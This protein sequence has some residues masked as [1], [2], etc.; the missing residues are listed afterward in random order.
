ML[1]QLLL[2]AAFFFELWFLDWIQMCSLSWSCY[3]YCYFTILTPPVCYDNGESL[4][5]TNLHETD[6]ILS[7]CVHFFDIP[8][9]R[10]FIF[11]SII[12]IP[13]STYLSTC[14]TNLFSIAGRIIWSYHRIISSIMH[15]TTMLYLISWL[16]SPYNTHSISEQIFS[17]MSW[18]ILIFGKHFSPEHWA[19]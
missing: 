16:F 4:F 5:D 8:A 9:M 1:S 18:S 15:W 14:R 10:S 12:L 6:M 13:F 17:L 2:C 11:K 3:C 19:L 7:Y